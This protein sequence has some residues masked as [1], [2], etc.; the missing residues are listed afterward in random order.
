MMLPH[1][2]SGAV[3]TP[4]YFSSRRVALL[5]LNNSVRMQSGMDRVAVRAV[6]VVTYTQ[7]KTQ[8]AGFCGLRTDGIS[9]GRSRLGAVESE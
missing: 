2:F 7:G 1:H 8:T 3:N 4:R 6:Q 9:D 5:T